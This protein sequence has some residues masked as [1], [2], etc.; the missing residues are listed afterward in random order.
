MKKSI[1]FFVT[2]A[3]M[4]VATGCSLMQALTLK[5]CN[6]SY[7]GISDVHLADFTQL[8]MTVHV[9]VENPN[10]HTASLEQLIYKVSL[11]S[12][13]IGGG[14]STQPLMVP[15][16]EVGE[17]PLQLNINLKNV[18]SGEYR[19]ALMKTLRNMMGWSS[20]PTLI[21]IS[22]RPSIRF[23]NSTITSPKYIPISFEYTGKK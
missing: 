7:G 5:D 8:T 1:V 10:K 11:D 17:L 4:V 18:L 3:L 14:T 2:I 19:A 21:T 23:G 15:G 13:E 12:V 9:K 6:Y 20:E 22:L 16:G